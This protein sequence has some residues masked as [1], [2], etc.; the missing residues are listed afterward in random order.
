MYDE[1][2]FNLMV[3]LGPTASGKTAL[4]VRLARH[5]EA[6]HGT[7][8]EIISADSRQ[9]YCGM[10]LGTG[11]DLEQFT[12]GGTPVHCH[13][14]D[15]VDPHHEFNLFEF[16]QAF[17]RVFSDIKNRGAFPLMVG[18]T[19]LYIEAVT[20]GYDLPAA[21]D[22]E[23]LKRLDELP[24][25][26]LRSLRRRYLELRGTP[27]NTTDVLDATRLARAIIIE[28]KRRESAEADR[29]PKP[30]VIPCV[31]GIRVERSRLR[32]L[33]RRRLLER[34]EKGMIDEVRD[35]HAAGLSWQRLDSFGLEYRYIA[36]HLRGEL[37][38]EKMIEIL[39][40]R[41]GQF[42]KRQETWFRR[43]ERRGTVI[44]WIDRGDFDSLRSLVD[45]QGG[46][47]LWR[48]E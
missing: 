9:V 15:I 11:K 28:E 5:I 36:R 20:K 40:I 47:S 33:I 32:D 21:F 25:R 45:A 3:L 34:I 18:G 44:H 48:R 35:L 29:A 2:P 42:A 8:V 10:D 37:S 31:I 19:G 17:Y 22:S 27:H 4:A 24:D 30:C 13:M 26:D 12:G 7:T 38:R 23:G 41:I 14:I 43:M 1:P 39:A 16:Q 6:L 46:H